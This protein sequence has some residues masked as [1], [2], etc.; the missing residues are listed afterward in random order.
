MTSG[1]RWHT[2]LNRMSSTLLTCSCGVATSSRGRVDAGSLTTKACQEVSHLLPVFRDS[3]RACRPARRPRHACRPFLCASTHVSSSQGTPASRL[4]NAQ[5]NYHG[6][7]GAPP[8]GVDPRSADID[9]NTILSDRAELFDYLMQ[10]NASMLS[11]HI[12][13]PSP[14]ETT[15]NDSWAS[16]HTPTPSPTSRPPGAGAPPVSWNSRGTSDPSGPRRRRSC[17]THPP[18]APATPLQPHVSGSFC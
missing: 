18:R 16:D 1:R 14:A 3:I 17:C 11:M 15:P 2:K 10:T 12:N 13:V 5:M 6:G 7:Q 4:T 9:E 8:P